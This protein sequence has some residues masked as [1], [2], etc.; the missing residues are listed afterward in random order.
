[1]NVNEKNAL[2][3][4]MLDFLDMYL[5]WHGPS[6]CFYLKKKKKLFS[7][8]SYT[9]AVK[10]EVFF[11]VQWSWDFLAKVLEI[12]EFHDGARLGLFRIQNPFFGKTIEEVQIMLDLTMDLDEKKRS[13]VC[14]RQRVCGRML[15]ILGFRFIKG[16]MGGEGFYL[17]T[18][19]EKPR[20]VADD[21]HVWIWELCPDSFFERIV[22]TRS[23]C[24]RGH[25]DIV[26]NVFFEKALRRSWSCWT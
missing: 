23:F 13:E 18:N 8:V 2:C 11:T 14:G 15:G 26:E 4:K 22:S 24:V 9:D 17:M 12:K 16:A 6:S 20:L 25:Y 1:M 5:E 7:H 10:G 19:D 21:R 3:K